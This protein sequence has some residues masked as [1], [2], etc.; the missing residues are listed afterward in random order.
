MAILSKQ[1]IEKSRTDDVKSLSRRAELRE[2]ELM[3]HLKSLEAQHGSFYLIN[4]QNVLAVLL[5]YP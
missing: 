3:S 1:S 2:E 4:Y 5:N